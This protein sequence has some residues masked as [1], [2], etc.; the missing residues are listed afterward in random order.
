MKRIALKDV[1]LLVIANSFPNKNNSYHGGI[2]VKEQVNELGKYLKEITVVSPQPLGANRTLKSYSYDNIKVY[3][4]LFFHLPINHFRKR[5]GDNI[6]KAT[7]RLIEK[8][9]IEFDIIHAHFTWPSGYAGVKL[10]KKFGVPVVVHIHENREWFMQEYNSGREEIYWTWKN[11]D[12]LIRVNRIDVPLLQKFNDSV[13]YIPNGFDPERLRVMSKKEAREYFGLSQDGKILFSLGNLIERKGFQ[14][15][16]TAMV[17]IVR[18]RDDVFC[19][20][21]G[22]GP[23]KDKLQHQINSLGL[24]NHVKL[25]GFVPDEELA[26]WMNAADLFVLPSLSESFGV[27]QI[28]AMAVGTPVVATINGGSEEIITSEDYG[29]LCPPADPECLAEKI[30]IALE[31]EWDREKIRKYAEQFT[32]ENVVM[33]ILKV[34]TSRV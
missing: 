13:Y 8:E 5:L 9:N 23:L 21:G 11:A 3:F 19:F 29:L 30:L 24:R 4:P 25:L 2:F 27:V 32:W 15:L 14:Y 16:I 6:F 28:E 33:Q 20:I 22:S 18:K 10:G 26:Y 31:K 1:R 34:Y 7:E 17:R 12:A